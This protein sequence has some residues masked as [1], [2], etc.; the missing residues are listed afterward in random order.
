[1]CLLRKSYRFDAESGI[2]CLAG[3][4]NRGDLNEFDRVWENQH[5]DIHLHPL[6][7]ETYDA[8]ITMAKQGYQDYLA[9]VVVSPSDAEA[10][11]ILRSFN[12]FQI[13]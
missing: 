4:V 11:S 1:M 9:K 3:A 12:D 7:T 2:G 10:K 13:L 5:D 6:S 8:L